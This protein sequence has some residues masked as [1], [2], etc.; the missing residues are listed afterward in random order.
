MTP[1]TGTITFLFTDIEGSTRLWQAQ[2]EAMAVALQRHDVLIH[3]TLTGHGGHIFKTVGDAFCSAFPAAHRAVEAALAALRALAAEPWPAA[4]GELRVRVALHTGT[5]EERDG[6]YFGPTL[7]RVARLLAAGHG[8]QVLLSAAAAELAAERLPA[9]VALRDLGSHRLKD[10]IAP[11]TIY[12]LVAGDLPDAF[13][14]LRFV[15]AARH[16]LPIQVTP[17]I[18]RQA[19]VA[20]VS[21]LLRR[22]D[23]RL[24]TLTGVG[25]T[26]KTRLSLQVAAEVV[27]EYEHGVFFVNLAQVTDPQA[28][29][30]AVLDALQVASPSNESPQVILERYIAGRQMLLLLDNFEQVISGAPLVGTMLAVAP[31]LEFLVTSRE[32]LVI[33]GEYEY[34]VPPLTLP[35]LAPSFAV[36]DYL[37]YEAVKLFVERAAAA[38]GDFQLNDDNARA[39]AE[40]CARL[41][42][43]P[44]AI[45]LAAARMRLFTPEALLVR[46][47]ERLDALGR[48]MRDRPERQQT[49][50]G[51]IDWSYNLLDEWERM[52]FRRLSVFRGGWEID[53]A[54]IVCGDDAL[55]VLGGLESLLN[56]S[57][58][59]RVEG[60]AA[61]PRFTMLATIGEYA[62]EQ[63]ALS[64][65]EPAIRLRH[66]GYFHRLAA[67]GAAELRTHN[68][69]AWMTR[70]DAEIENIRAA[71]GY[72]LDG[73]DVARGVAMTAQLRDYWFNS[74]KHTEGEVW[75]GRAMTLVDRAEPGIR[76]DLMIALGIMLQYR[77]KIVESA[78][79]L[80][81]AEVVA[82]QLDDPLRLAWVIIWQSV[83]RAVLDGRDALPELRRRA[84]E[85]VEWLRAAGDKPGISQALNIIGENLRAAGD[86]DAAEVV[87][88]EV[89]PLAE[90]IGDW[91]RVVFQ[92]ANLSAIGYGRGEATTMLRNARLGLPLSVEYRVGE[93]TA[94]FLIVLA[95]LFHRTGR[96]DVA[97]RLIGAADGWYEEMSVVPQPSDLPVERRMKAEVR[98]GMDEAEYG[99]AWAVGRALSLPE[100]A[101]LAEQEMAVLEGALASPV[102][103]G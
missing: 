68:Q 14:P 53:A 93:T 77:N 47:S 10:L 22:P 19:Q 70:L 61:E 30:P 55:D 63:L 2:P 84:Q 8:G 15:E 87:Y 6:D 76:V 90:E 32:R 59:R 88:Q 85:S 39:V 49:L 42:G 5:A 50:R 35:D 100:G 7:N 43:L 74:Y 75:L 102:E 34:A 91:R 9:G 54:E 56:K 66:A 60:P 24:I 78:R 58:I 29:A 101:A 38:R 16:N 73:G 71:L 11:E 51:A 96:G 89:I 62:R 4:T 72:L 82:A 94:Y 86:L 103:D 64:A 80:E 97:G 1:P 12:Q 23:V 26:G 98:Q 95:V 45:E 3:E 41:D 36:A 48:G 20:A 79:L 67:A 40:I 28:I 37:E 31:R 33:S 65:E 52:L 18:G 44:L 92:Y 69:L 99:R 83:S 27:D 13:P 25:G 57:L 17:L 81:Q 46:L 21:A